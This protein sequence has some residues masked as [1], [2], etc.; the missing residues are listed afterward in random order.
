MARYFFSSIERFDFH[1]RTWVHFSGKLIFVQH[2]L[3]ENLKSKVVDRRFDNFYIGNFT[4]DGAF[5]FSNI[6]KG[7]FEIKEYFETFLNLCPN[8]VSISTGTIHT[9][10]RKKLL[11]IFF[12]LLTN[13]YWRDENFIS[14]NNNDC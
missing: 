5:C 14:F 9:G 8:R 12:F 13:S 7:N 4:L 1:A 11:I 10:N 3:L 6:K 2:K